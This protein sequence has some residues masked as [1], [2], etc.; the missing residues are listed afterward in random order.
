MKIRL[1]K[2]LL[3]LAVVAIVPFA[4]AAPAQAAREN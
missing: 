4:A 1:I 3:I 2:R